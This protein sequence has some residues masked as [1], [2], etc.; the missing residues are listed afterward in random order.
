MTQWH[1]WAFS[2]LLSANKLFHHFS[3]GQWTLFSAI[4][5]ETAIWRKK[6]CQ[7]KKGI[8]FVICISVDCYYSFSVVFE[9]KL[10]ASWEVT[11]MYVNFQ[12]LLDPESVRWLN[13]VVERVWPICMEQIA[14]QQFLLPIIPWFLDNYKPWTAVWV[15]PLCT[16]WS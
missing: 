8:K 11:I 12:L 15:L 13:R 3:K 7:Q 4:G 10:F 14:S 5:K 9:K 6:I 1:T 16:L 2:Y